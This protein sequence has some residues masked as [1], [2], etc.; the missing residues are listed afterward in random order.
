MSV[1]HCTPRSKGGSDLGSNLFV[2]QT[3]DNNFLGAEQVSDAELF[4]YWRLDLLAHKAEY[5][6]SKIEHF[7][8]LRAFLRHTGGG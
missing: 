4:Y 6:R 7:K 3:Q 5:F 1:G 8:T 2:Q